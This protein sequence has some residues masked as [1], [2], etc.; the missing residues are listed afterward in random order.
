ML[1]YHTFFKKNFMIQ[2]IALVLLQISL[3]FRFYAVLR[4]S[5]THIVEVVSRWKSVYDGSGVAILGVCI[6]LVLYLGICLGTNRL[7]LSRYGLNVAVWQ[8]IFFVSAYLVQLPLQL[9]RNEWIAI[10]VDIF[11]LVIW[12]S[13]FIAGLCG[14]I[15]TIKNDPHGNQGI[16]IEDSKMMTRKSCMY[17][18]LP[19]LLAIVAEGSCRALYFLASLEIVRQ[20]TEQLSWI[21]MAGNIMDGVFLHVSEWSLACLAVLLIYRKMKI[22]TYLLGNILYFAIL[23]MILPLIQYMLNTMFVNNVI[24]SVWISLITGVKIMIV[25]V[26]AFGIASLILKK[27]S[28][29]RV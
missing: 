29:Q 22:S 7:S 25:G 26:A 10:S 17:F 8:I 21:S 19:I 1:S 14:F 2:L 5:S 11:P 9:K 16:H 4:I 6:G 3:F 23:F 15:Q 20:N 28:H 18:G 27:G 13:I 12:V 24:F